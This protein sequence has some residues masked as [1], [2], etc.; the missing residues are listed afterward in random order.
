[1]KV[2]VST[3]S[4]KRIDGSSVALFSLSCAPLRLPRGLV[5]RVQE[6]LSSPAMD[7]D[8]F[9][10]QPA[11]REGQDRPE[12]SLYVLRADVDAVREECDRLAARQDVVKEERDRLAEDVKILG[13]TY[14]NLAY[15][16]ESDL[17]AG[18]NPAYLSTMRRVLEA[19]RAIEELSCQ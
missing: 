16:R 19:T 18:E 8:D 5:L 13:D 17:P 7:Q 14:A 1:M 10:P 6:R 11:K 9:V 12:S 2:R 4:R 15:D 3:A